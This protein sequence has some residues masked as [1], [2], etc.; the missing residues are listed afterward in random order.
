MPNDIFDK[1]G[2]YGRIVAHAPPNGGE[3]R[4]TVEVDGRRVLVPANAVKRSRRGYFLPMR[5]KD[6]APAPETESIV[7][8]VM[9]ERLRVETQPYEEKV[10][11]E[12]RVQ[13]RDEWVEVPTVGEEIAIERVAVNREVDTPVDAHYEGETLVIPLFEEE[14][15][16]RKRLVLREEIRIT[17]RRV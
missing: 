14:V 12:K 4:L 6:L 3:E 7:V 2:S 16:T 15:V 10:T 9:E 5:F 1:D 11:V 8:P 17:K 13:T